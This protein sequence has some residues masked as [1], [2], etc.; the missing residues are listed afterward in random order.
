MEDNNVAEV[1]K[2]MLEQ[3][4]LQCLDVGLTYQADHAQLNGNIASSA[5]DHIYCSKDLVQSIEL[6]KLKNSATDIAGCT[7]VNTLVYA[8]V[9]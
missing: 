9:G 4:G 5:L 1:L 8:C 7:A 6:K 2:N 3:E